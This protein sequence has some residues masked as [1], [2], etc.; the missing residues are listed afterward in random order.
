[1][2]SE[3]VGMRKVFLGR[4]L[5]QNGALREIGCRKGTYD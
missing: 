1:M 4:V 3:K 2:G 5:G